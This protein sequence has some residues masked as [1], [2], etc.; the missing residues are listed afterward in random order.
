MKK[1]LLLIAFVCTLLIECKPD[2][3][4]PTVDTFQVQEIT[5][6]TAH[7]LGYVTDNGN[8]TIIA[9][10]FCWSTTK[11]PSLENGFTIKADCKEEEKDKVVNIMKNVMENI[12][13]LEVPLKIDVEYGNN[14]YEAK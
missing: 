2:P 1:Y 9:K 13:K 4:L 12:C 8:A 11:N 3:E 14:W 7:C 10:G 5:G 6:T